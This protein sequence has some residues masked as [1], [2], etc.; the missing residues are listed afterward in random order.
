MIWAELAFFYEISGLGFDHWMTFTSGHTLD[1]W[2]NTIIENGKVSDISGRHMVDYFGD[3]AVEY[4]KEY[5]SEQPFFLQVSYDGPYMDPPTNMG[6]AKNRH[7]EYYKDKHLSSFPNEPVSKNY[8]DQLVDFAKQGEDK[9]FLNRII[10]M[11]IG[12]MAG[13]QATRANMASQNTLVD[14]NVGRLLH[15]LEEKGLDENTIVIYSSDQGVY[16]GQHGLWTHTILS[17][18]STLQ[19]TAFQIPLIVRKPGEAEGKTVTSL[20][21]QYDIPATILDLAGVKDKLPNSP[22]KSFSRMLGT[23]KVGE[24]HDAVFYEQ[25]ETRG[26]RTQKYAYWKRMDEKF[27]PNELYDMEKDPYQR[28]NLAGKK[29]YQAVIAKLDNRLEAFHSRYAD[30]KYDL[31]K[32]GTAKGTISYPKKFKERFG[33]SWE[34]KTD[35]LPA[36][37]E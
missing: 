37:A 25:T 14:D 31:W 7:Y 29:E 34:L 17:Q 16:Y 35:I 4:I 3:K 5:D 26:I 13:D 33:E 36:Y 30:P 6:P 18:P 27:G 23:K 9:E 1:F 24:I 15:A 10:K 2:K 21:G 8:V 22:G 12:N 20:I 19:E 11:V 28:H 32:G